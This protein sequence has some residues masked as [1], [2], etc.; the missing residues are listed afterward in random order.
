MLVEHDLF[1]CQ[2]PPHAAQYCHHDQL[3]G[4]KFGRGLIWTPKI[5]PPGTK[6]TRSTHTILFLPCLAHQVPRRQNTRV[7]STASYHLMHT[8]KDNV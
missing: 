8:S 4:S 2:L 1:N 3:F 7:P 5:R 6:S